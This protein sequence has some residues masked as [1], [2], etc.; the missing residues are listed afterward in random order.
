MAH[1]T[2]RP[3]AVLRRCV[4]TLAM[5]LALAAGTPPALAGAGT[6]T[7]TPDAGTQAAITGGDFEICC[8]SSPDVPG[9]L[10]RGGLPECDPASNCGTHNWEPRYFSC[11]FT[12]CGFDG[13]FVSISASGGFS[14]KITLEITD[15]PPG[16]TSQTAT[17]V[18]IK[19]NR[20]FVVTGFV[21]SAASSAPTGDFLVTVRGTSGSLVRERQ[22]LVRIVDQ[23]PPLLEIPT[24]DP[25]SVPGG[26]PT[27]G[28]VTLASPA[29]AGGVAVTLSSSWQPE[30]ITIPDSVTI[31]AGATS[32][33]FPVSTNPVSST[34]TVSV[35]AH[36]L[37]IFP[38]GPGTLTV[39][40]Q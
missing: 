26:D 19:K 3:A 7:G 10:V 13:A 4:L 32:A 11:G 35:G 37:N 29:P 21:L 9:Y 38:L 2:P 14:G 34:T 8:E 18:Q 33:T 20:T 27:T 17:S 22:R 36:Y 24:F 23:L 25:A 12:A 31:P 28:T 39:T 30:V 5:V 6:G 1:L 40:S 15:L 16:V